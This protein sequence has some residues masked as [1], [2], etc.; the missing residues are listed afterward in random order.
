[1]SKIRCRTFWLLPLAFI[2]LLADQSRVR[3]D[4]LI[5]DHGFLRVTI[6]GRPARLESLTVKRANVSERLPIALITHG[7]SANPGKMLDDHATDYAGPARDLAR[8]G[9]L[10][11]VVMR[12]GF[13]QSDGP[14][15]TPVSC[16][17]TSLVERFTADADDLQAALESISQRSDADPTRIIAIGVSAGGAAVVALSARNPA[18]LAGVINVSGGLRMR[19]CPEGNELVAAMRHFGTTSHVPN[20]WLYAK[21]DSFFPPELVERM[22]SAFLDSGGNV[23]LVMFESIGEDGHSM[24]RS[25]QGRT[26]W[27]FEMDGFLRFRKLPTWQ[28]QDVSALM[29]KF[30]AADR[31]RAFFESYIA[32][33]TEKALARSSSSQYWFRITGHKAIESARDAA[34]KG[35]QKAK[36]AEQ[37]SIVMEND[38]LV[39]TTP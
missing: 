8:R 35:C 9:W 36:P 25:W 32:A 27:L 23:K 6:N 30:K 1:M 22:D 15:S 10:T 29:A 20:L 4:D 7:K 16:Q 11:V 26:K 33:P 2:V 28:Q 24:F 34:V 12:R 13:G 18:N 38:N 39:A 31:S 17:T 37:C 3:A 21:N 19:Q 5:E 14:I